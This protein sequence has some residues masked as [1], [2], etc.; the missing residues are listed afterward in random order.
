M[1]TPLC[2]FFNLIHVLFTYFVASL[3]SKSCNECPKQQQDD[4]A[5]HLRYAM[6]GFQFRQGTMTIFALIKSINTPTWDLSAICNKSTN[7]SIQNIFRPVP[8]SIPQIYR[9]YF[10]ISKARGNGGIFIS[11]SALTRVIS[12]MNCKYVLLFQDS[13][14]HRWSLIHG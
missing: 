12:A 1:V 2:S 8:L 14:V 6:G 9:P 4:R 13:Y 7:S 3:I 5:L 11:N 10:I